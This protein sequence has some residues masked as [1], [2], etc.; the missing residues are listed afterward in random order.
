MN[1]PVP[2]ASL[3]TP[4]EGGVTELADDVE[5]WVRATFLDDGATVEN[6]E[7]EHLRQAEIGFVWTNQPNERK[8]RTVLG[9]CQL[10]PPSGEKW[11]AAR[12]IQQLQDWFFIVPD[13]LITLYAPA[14][15]EMDDASFMA[16]VEHELLHAAQKRDNYGAP[17][18]NRET[19]KPVWALRGHDVEQFVSVVRRYGA[20]AAGVR[21]MVDAA[22]SGPEIAPARVSI[23]C[24]NCLRLVS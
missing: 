17:M 22:N 20:D 15:A 8:G 6:P 2:P 14:C 4:I 9:T 1:R 18:F 11:S 19:G 23:A 5:P 10:L 7:H 21:E 24:G 12:A 16:L 13:F 3:W